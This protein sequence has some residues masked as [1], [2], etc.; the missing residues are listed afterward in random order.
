[1]LFLSHKRNNNIVSSEIMGY[2]VNIRDSNALD[3]LDIKIEYNI[4]WM[5]HIFQVSK[6]AFKYLGF[7][8]W[9]RKYFTSSLLISSRFTTLWS[10]QER[11]ASL[12]FGAE[13]QSL[14][15]DFSTAYRKWHR[16]LLALSWYI[17]A[18]KQFG[19]GFIVLTLP[20]LI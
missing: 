1:M 16:R 17:R 8:R 10:N 5:H 7:L 4:R 15:Q 14:F 13:P 11:N 6:E 12:T 3:V 19:L 9:C 18:S 2:G 20:Q